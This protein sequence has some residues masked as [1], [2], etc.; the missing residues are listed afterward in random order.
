M[1]SAC[2]TFYQ[3]QADV[4]DAVYNGNIDK[5]E[6][7]MSDVRWQKP[8][9]N[10]LLFY[11]NKGTILWMNGKNIESNKY[12]LQADLFVEDYRKNY[13]TELA[14]V[15]INPNYSTYCGESFEQILIHYYATINFVQ[16]G[17]LDNALVACK[18]MIATS[19]KINDLL[20]NKNKYRRDAFAHNLLGMLYDAQGDYNNAFIAYRNSLNIY[21]EDYKPQLG[22]E[23]PLQ[24]KKD[25]LRTAKTIY[26][27]EEVEKYEAEFNLKA[28]LLPEGYAP[29]VFFW[30]NGLGPIK[31]ENAINFV[32]YP[33]QNGY[34]NFVNVELGLSFPI[35]V[36]NAEDR[37]KVTSLNIV[38]VAWPKYVT[39]IPKFKYAVLKDSLNN[40]FKLDIGEDINAI[41]FKSLDDRMFKEISEA[42][43]RLAL[44]QAAIAYTKKENE[45]AG[46]ALSIL[47]AAT[48]K[49]DT[50]NWQFLPYSI[51]YTRAFLPIGK[52]NIVLETSSNNYTEKNN[53]FVNM[54]KGKT[55]FQAFQTLQFDGFADKQG[56]RI[57]MY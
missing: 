7:L 27:N 42:I 2:A 52:Q 4:M 57:N 40:V 24:L 11:L 54:Q 43:L 39:R 12:F 38:R 18:R 56:N 26:F 6:A 47:S 17:D 22:T 9:R 55:N 13:A 31:D 20:Q 46:V 53:F 35:Y 37:R 25:I 19:Q 45:G 49:A 21:K 44:K 3:K 1:L 28:E 51:N 41:A 5:A 33:L 10:R 48:E 23:I 32:V 50:R 16:L 8:A 15:L 30:N 36:G 34:V 29:L 14:S